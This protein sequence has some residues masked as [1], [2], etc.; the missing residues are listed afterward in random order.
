M[1]HRWCISFRGLSSDNAFS[2]SP[3]SFH[4]AR[5]R[6][7]S[8]IRELADFMDSLALP[9]RAFHLIFLAKTRVSTLVTIW[10]RNKE[11]R[12]QKR[13]R[14]RDR[15]TERRGKERDGR[16]RRVGE[17]IDRRFFEIAILTRMFLDA[18]FHVGSMALACVAE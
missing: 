4:C 17:L 10:P 16:Q 14:K 8:W 11:L 6:A 13:E 15:E 12:A 2:S 3:F 9:R 7:R 18:S 5:A 1:R